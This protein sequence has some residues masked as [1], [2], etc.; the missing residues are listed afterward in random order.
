MDFAGGRH[1]EAGHKQPASHHEQQPRGDELQCGA[2]FSDVDAH[3]GEGLRV[4][5]MVSFGILGLEGNFALSSETKLIYPD[6]SH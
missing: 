3:N 2:V 5:I 1:D 6:T 4:W